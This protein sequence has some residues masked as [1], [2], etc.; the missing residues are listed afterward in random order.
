MTEVSGFTKVHERRPAI[1]G[2]PPTLQVDHSHIVVGYGKINGNRL[3]EQSK[4]P[5]HVFGCKHPLDLQEAELQ[6][7]GH[8]TG[9]NSNLMM[10]CS[11][12]KIWNHLRTKLV[13]S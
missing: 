3:P 11:Q 1:L 9:A 10:P 13:G 7:R 2:Y 8:V 6:N 12:F 5:F 4:P